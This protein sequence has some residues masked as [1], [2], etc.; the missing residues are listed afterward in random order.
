LGGRLNDPL[1]EGFN[2]VGRE[3]ELPA[4][5]VVTREEAK[6]AERSDLGTPV[7]H[8][9][10]TVELPDGIDA[11]IVDSAGRS[12][13]TPEQAGWALALSSAEADVREQTKVLENPFAR[14]GQKRQAATNHKQLGL[15]PR[16]Q[17]SPSS[18]SGPNLDLQGG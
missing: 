13:M 2:L 14:A 3:I 18:G 1:P 15:A 11:T 9:Q 6:E 4:P 5:T 16:N 12:N 7:L 8:T 10:W 17:P